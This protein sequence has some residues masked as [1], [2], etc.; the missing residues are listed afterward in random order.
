VGIAQW[1]LHSREHI[2]LLR[3]GRTGLLLHTMFYAAEVRAIDEFRADTSRISDQEIELAT[4]LVKA[5]AGSFMPAKYKDNYQENLR[6]V[7]DAKIQGKEMEARAAQPA[8][9]PVVDILEAL[10]ASIARKKQPQPTTG[11][12]GTTTPRKRAARLKSAAG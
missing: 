12:A 6:A 11:E 7:L 1:T 2:V 10:R 9:A 3:A 8:L 5:L 4:M